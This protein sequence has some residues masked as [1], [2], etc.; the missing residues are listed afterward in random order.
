LKTITIN[1]QLLLII[2]K[3]DVTST[4]DYYE[5]MLDREKDI[6]E[7]EILI[8]TINVYKDFLNQLMR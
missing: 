5:F 3:E 2:L 1:S 7:R 4:I 8:D 6:M